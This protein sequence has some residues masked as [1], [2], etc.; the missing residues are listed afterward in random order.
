M[1]G[2]GQGESRRPSRR[3]RGDW[4]GTG[5]G[6]V[7]SQLRSRRKVKEGRGIERVEERKRERRPRRDWR[8]WGEG[9]TKT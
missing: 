4:E 8:G 2:E 6:G 3:Q 1:G 9:E 7:E 5:K